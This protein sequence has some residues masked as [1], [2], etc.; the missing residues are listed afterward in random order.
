MSD[1]LRPNLKRE[2]AM[3]KFL[4]GDATQ[5][6]M[7]HENRGR[8]VHDFLQRFFMVSCLHVF[9]LKNGPIFC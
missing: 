7:K 3:R 2:I 1:F 5:K 4:K 8:Y 9:L 6:N